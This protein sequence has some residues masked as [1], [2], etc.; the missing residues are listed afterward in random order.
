MDLNDRSPSAKSGAVFEESCEASVLSGCSAIFSVGE[1]V[2]IG[3]DSSRMDL[4][5]ERMLNGFG[6]L[7]L[8]FVFEVESTSDSSDLE[9]PPTGRRG[10]SF[11]PEGSDGIVSERSPKPILVKPRKDVPV[12]GVSFD[13]TRPDIVGWSVSLDMLSSGWTGRMVFSF[14]NRLELFA[15]L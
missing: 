5:R 10:T 15:A 4:V 8:L 1:V 7:F 14:C 13:E 3:L 9:R 6:L 12:L 2:S 11:S